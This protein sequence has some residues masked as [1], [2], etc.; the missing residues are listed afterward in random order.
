M[1]LLY[2]YCVRL[3]II[4]R[5][6]LTVMSL[7]WG[8]LGYILGEGKNYAEVETL[9]RIIYIQSTD[10]SRIRSSRWI[11]LRRQVRNEGQLVEALAEVQLLLLLA[12]AT[13]TVVFA[14]R[15]N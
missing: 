8:T 6:R 3:G 13:C 10:Q 2:S 11:G 14:Y 9:A 7:G 12:S 5:A 4:L 15:E 1:Q